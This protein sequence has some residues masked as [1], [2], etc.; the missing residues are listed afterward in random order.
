MPR[1]TPPAGD[2]LVGQL[3]ALAGIFG[4]L[5]Y[6]VEHGHVQGWPRRALEHRVRRLLPQVHTLATDA[7]LD[8]GFN[9]PQ[10]KRRRR[11]KSS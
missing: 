9:E 8:V 5:S 10:P 7:G 11:P 1:P 3:A 4:E 6:G 2:W